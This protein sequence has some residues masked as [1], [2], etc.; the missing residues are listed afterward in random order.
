MIASWFLQDVAPLKNIDWSLSQRTNPARDDRQRPNAIQAAAPVIL[1]H[2]VG[3]RQ[4][5]MPETLRSEIAL[6]RTQGFAVLPGFVPTSDLAAL[7]RMAREQLG[8]RVP[9]L[10]FEADLKYP[11]APASR[12]ARGGGTVRRLLQA[13]DRSD[14]FAAQAT[15]A[16][17]R[18]LMQQ[19]FAGDVCLSRAH[20]NCVMTKHPRY[21]SLTG[22]HRDI[23]YWSFE[24][25]DLVSVWFALGE[26]RI[27]NGGLWLVPESHLMAIDAGRF[28]AA[29]FLR[30]DRPEN[31]ALLRTAISQRLGPGDALLFHCNTLHAAG[32]N[33]SDA[34]KFSLVFTFHGPDNR[35]QPGTRSASLE[36]IQ[37]RAPQ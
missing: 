8:E 14:V 20:H 17:L 12:A 3:D 2:L 13:F 29:K 37:L 4:R 31:A 6:L 5:I 33:I 22:W 35:P 32:P 16:P 21:G 11:G 15:A 26:E 30:A 19:Y 34:V 25:E 36:E 18:E 24:H 27:D 10:E 23:R 28:D 9:P 7:N 1:S